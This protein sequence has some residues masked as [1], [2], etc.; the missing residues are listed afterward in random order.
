MLRER[1]RMML[2][3]LAHDAI[4]EREA[5]A[6]MFRTRNVILLETQEGHK[7]NLD[8]ADQIILTEMHAPKGFKAHGGGA[9]P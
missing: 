2:L 6:R 9:A 1:L 8:D 5:L 3:P 7:H 4:F